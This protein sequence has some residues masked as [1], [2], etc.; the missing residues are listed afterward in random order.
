MTYLQYLKGEMEEA[1]SRYKYSSGD[2]P[3]GQRTLGEIKIVTEGQNTTVAYE[4][5]QI[6]DEIVLPMVEKIG[7]ILA[8]MKDEDETIRYVNAKGENAIGIID[9]SVRTA[10]YSYYVS[11]PANSAS[12]KIDKIDYLDAVLTKIAPYMNATK[13][14]KLNAKEL[15][16]ILSNSFDISNPDKMIL[17]EEEQVQVQ[18]NPEQIRFTSWST[19]K[20]TT[21]KADGRGTNLMALSDKDKR[22]I[23]ELYKMSETDG[24]Y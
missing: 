13:Q 7:Q 15:L 2:S 19:T 4:I 8:N 14:G 11:E 22:E 17:V 18:V 20:V 24:R 5:D 9:N 1:T 21:I 23:V 16:K 10:E 3:K 6:Y 12:R